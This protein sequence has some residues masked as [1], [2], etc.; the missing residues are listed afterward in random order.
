MEPLEILNLLR[1]AL[2]VGASLLRLGQ[3]HDV[4]RGLK[5]VLGQA[6]PRHRA[7]LDTPQGTQLVSS[8][9]IDRALLAELMDAVD[10]AQ[11]RYR[12]ALRAAQTPEARR[13]AD[14]QAEQEI[15]EHL[16]RIRARNGGALPLE[17][18]RTV[19]QSYSCEGAA[20][21]QGSVY[22]RVHRRQE[23]GD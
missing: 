22:Q 19:W 11:Q 16:T 23:V 5:N 8:L 17:A 14:L 4:P 3:C 18:L 13:A 2:S 7:L 21:Q 15:C 9:V 1:A 6:E 20:Q 10:G 12:R